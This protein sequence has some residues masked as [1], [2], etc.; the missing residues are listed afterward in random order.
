MEQLNQIANMLD[1][2]IRPAF[3]VQ[4]GTIVHVNPNAQSYNITVGTQVTDLLKTG[5]SEYADFI[6][7]SLYLTLSLSGVTLGACVER[8]ADFQVFLLDTQ[9]QQAELHAMALAARE[10]REP[11]TTAM[12]AAKTLNNAPSLNRGLFQMLR[13]IGNMS[14]AERYN[15]NTEVLTE[16]RNIS[17]VFDEIFDQAIPLVEKTGH[18]LHFKG[19]NQSIYGLINKDRLER[20]VHNLI[21]NA[22]KFSASSSPIYATLSKKGNFLYFTIENQPAESDAGLKNNVFSRFLREPGIE[23]GRFGIGLGMVVVRSAASAHGGTVLL[24]Q[25]DNSS[26]R[27]TMTISIKQDTNRIVRS[28]ILS[29]DYAGE[30]N[31][32]LLELSDVLPDCVYNK[33]P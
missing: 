23:D 16:T 28:H 3:C 9:N 2:M 29:I 30:W 13:I 18:Q 5:V 19:I 17:A 1:L 33:Y 7:G 24:E 11:L 25:Q 14:D 32:C 26:I 15:R 6:D 8:V 10:L 21:S 27:V 31:R 20:A 22:V 4:N 12:T